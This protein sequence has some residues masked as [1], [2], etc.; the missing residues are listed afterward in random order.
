MRDCRRTIKRN[1]GF[2][3]HDAEQLQTLRQPLVPGLTAFDI[4]LEHFN[5]FEGHPR[6]LARVHKGREICIEIVDVFGAC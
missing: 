6:Q 4:G 2:L 3:I 5:D 1:G